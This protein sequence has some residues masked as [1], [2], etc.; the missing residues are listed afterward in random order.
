MNTPKS[1]TAVMLTIIGVLTVTVLALLIVIVLM[2]LKPAEMK[3]SSLPPGFAPGVGRDY[4]TPAQIRQ[5]D[6]DRLR[7]M[8][9]HEETFHTGNH[10]RDITGLRTKLGLKPGQPI[11][12]K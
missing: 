4:E 7:V 11:P 10:T 5:A 1:A 9:S 12:D 6:L 8:E 3:S 2:A